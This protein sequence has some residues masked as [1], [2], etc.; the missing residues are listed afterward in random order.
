MI[1]TRSCYR[2]V[3]TDPVRYI[4]ELR[5]WWCP[6]YTL[7]VGPG[8]SL[9][10]VVIQQHCSEFANTT[11]AFRYAIEHARYHNK[12]RFKVVENLGRL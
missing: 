8:I 10:G 7:A 5:K 3:Q 1:D 6:F 11:Q 12:P 2:I 4:V 9:D